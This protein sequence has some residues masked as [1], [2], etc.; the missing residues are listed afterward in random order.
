MSRPSRIIRPV[1]ITTYI[2]EDLRAQLALFL[3]SEVEGRIPLGAYA[4][5][6]TERIRE[7][8]TNQ[9]KTEHK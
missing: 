3:Y 1:K 9:A 7:F 2:P 5:F 8:F 4:N 6:F